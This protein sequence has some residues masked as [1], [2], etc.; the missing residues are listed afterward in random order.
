MLEY[1]V[2]VKCGWYG[3]ACV[4]AAA[5]QL[6]GPRI[7]HDPVCGVCTFPFVF[8]RALSH[9]PKTMGNKGAVNYLQWQKGQK[10]NC[11]EN[12]RE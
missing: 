4:S 12:G 10:G 8:T 11:L 3:G 2:E 7:Y 1:P 5:S 9:I 6:Q